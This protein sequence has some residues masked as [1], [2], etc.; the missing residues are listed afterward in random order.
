MGMNEEHPTTP[1]SSPPPAASLDDL[2]V[3]A[4]D[5]H[6]SD[7]ET[8]IESNLLASPEAAR[9]E[10]ALRDAA[11][12]LATGAD[13]V[14]P[15][16]HLRQRILAAAF[17]RRPPGVDQGGDTG[18]GN[19]AG[20]G[21]GDGGSPVEIHRTELRR[22]LDLLDGLAADEWT[23]PVDPPEFAGWTVHDLVV[24]LAA[25]ESLLATR[26]DVPVPGVPETSGD[27]AER[28]AAAHARH[29]GRPPAAALAE[30]RAAAAAV[31]ERVSALDADALDATIDWWGR[32]TPV[33][34][35][36]LVRAF[37]TWTHA[38]DIRRA[39]GLP[40]L[41]APP[42]SLRTM[43]Q[44][45]CGWVPLML[46]ARGIRRPGR[47]VRFTFTDVPGAA[48]D[49]ALDQVGDVRPAGTGPT[50]A[51]IA[52]DAE[53]FCRTVG[54]RVP[55]AELRYRSTGDTGLAREVIDAVPALAV[56]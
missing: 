38:D 51:T 18:A 40:M 30:L 56:L 10:R 7:D 16:P 24:H 21:E 42:A 25:N 12:E 1:Q 55:T 48:Y 34:I 22:V 4:L 9:W 35:A 53:S 54:N 8:A 41:P 39:V 14:A 26:L 11:G 50:D 28:T 13:E 49:V 37:E 17:R 29:R 52:I 33:R 19:G 45:A 46:A 31:G 36:L 15:P 27:N 32:P 20:A 23:H 6:E 5:A 47:V 3:Y 43:T 2:A 44:T